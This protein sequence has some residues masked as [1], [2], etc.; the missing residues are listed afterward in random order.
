MEQRSREV[1]LYNSIVY[2]YYSKVR[3]LDYNVNSNSFLV[4]GHKSDVRMNSHASHIYRNYRFDIPACIHPLYIKPN[5]DWYVP[6]AKF[7][8]GILNR[9]VEYIVKK[10]DLKYRIF[11]EE[12]FLQTGKYML[13][14]VSHIS[15]RYGSSEYPTLHMNATRVNS[16]NQQGDSLV[17]TYMYTKDFPMKVKRIFKRNSHG[18]TYHDRGVRVTISN[19]YRPFIASVIDM[20]GFIFQID[21]KHLTKNPI[22]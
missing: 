9:N 8:M 22:I 3:I 11:P 6:E 17:G 16:S 2:L 15:D 13:I 18:I 1:I 19:E 20:E 14:P 10:N 7:T 5:Y 12:D 4:T 21:I